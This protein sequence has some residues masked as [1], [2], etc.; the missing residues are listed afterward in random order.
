M[1]VLLFDMFNPLDNLG[2]LFL[3]VN[4]W[5][6]SSVKLTTHFSQDNNT[7]IKYSKTGRYDNANLSAEI[8]LKFM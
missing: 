1:D 5:M 3:I 2:Q 4:E 7:W 6:R 8:T